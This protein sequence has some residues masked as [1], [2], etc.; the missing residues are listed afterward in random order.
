M[1]SEQ[2]TGKLI[3]IIDMMSDMDSVVFGQSWKLDYRE[4]G[5][6]AN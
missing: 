1:K 6:T 4:K 3:V 5:R 2:S